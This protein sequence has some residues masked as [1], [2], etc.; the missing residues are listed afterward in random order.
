MQTQIYS[1]YQIKNAIVK[2]EVWFAHLLNARMLL[3]CL[4]SKYR[5][6]SMI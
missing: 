5:V 3:L 4:V 1:N 6:F 2:I